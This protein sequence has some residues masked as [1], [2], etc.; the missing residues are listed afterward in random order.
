MPPRK[1]REIDELWMSRM[2][3]G[4][5]AERADFEDIKNDASIH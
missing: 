5:V 2:S 3:Q 1:K 4:M